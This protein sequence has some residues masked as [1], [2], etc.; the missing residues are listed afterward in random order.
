METLSDEEV[1][2][3]MFHQRSQET[4]GQSEMLRPHLQK[5][6]AISAVLRSGER[7]KVASL[8]DESATEQD[9]IQLFFK[10]IQHYTPTLI[11]W[12]GSGFDL[13]VLH[14]RA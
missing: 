4:N 13:P 6:I 9:I 1:A 10:T 7:L 2:K 12:N 5:V 11:S 3:V 14:Y 8:G